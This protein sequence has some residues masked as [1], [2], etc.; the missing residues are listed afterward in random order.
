MERKAV[1]TWIRQAV[2]GCARRCSRSVVEC[3]SAACS[4]G[5]RCRSWGPSP[6]PPVLPFPAPASP[7]P[8]KAP[9]PLSHHHRLAMAA[10]NSLPSGLAA[11]ASRPPIQGFTTITQKNITVN[12]GRGRRHRLRP[13]ARSGQRN[14][15]SHL[16]HSGP[17]NAERLGRS[18]RRLPQRR[19]SPAERPQLHVP[20]PTRRRRQ[21]AAGGHPRQRR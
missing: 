5:H 7:S 10:T 12:V 11:T 3:G 16:H 8:T 14:R 9:T 17:R 19:Q 21:H 6:T 15:R 18:S 4:G 20:R 1:S 13:Q 2:A